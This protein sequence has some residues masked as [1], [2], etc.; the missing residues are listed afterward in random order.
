MLHFPKKH[1]FYNQIKQLEKLYGETIIR[2]LADNR[3][4]MKC[5][6]FS[7][8]YYQKHLV[9][10]LSLHFSKWHNINDKNIH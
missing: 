3:T 1:D 6:L 7:Y 8:L 10:H 5:F 9:F 4:I 2:Y